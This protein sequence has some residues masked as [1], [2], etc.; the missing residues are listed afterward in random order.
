MGLE[1]VGREGKIEECRIQRRQQWNCKIDEESITA[2]TLV[3]RQAGKPR[4]LQ[5]PFMH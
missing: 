3:Y 4:V 2:R 5:L 1:L